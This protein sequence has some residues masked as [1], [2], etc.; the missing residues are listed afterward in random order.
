MKGLGPR[1]GSVAAATP[2][3]PEKFGVACAR[4]AVGG[5][6]LRLRECI[7]R[8]ELLLTDLLIEDNY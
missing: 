6:L 4:G 1:S 2:R 8:S 7:R 3:R 5:L